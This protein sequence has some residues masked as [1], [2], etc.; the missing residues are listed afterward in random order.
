MVEQGSGLAEAKESLGIREV[1]SSELESLCRELIQKNPSVV[2]DVRAGKMKAI[3]A[4]IGQARKLNPNADP[5]AV[6]KLL[7]ELLT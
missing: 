2:A 7:L 3:G 6:R 1:D 5:G 4:L